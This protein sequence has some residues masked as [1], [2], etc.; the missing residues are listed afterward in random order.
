MC[1]PHLVHRAKSHPIPDWIDFGVAV[2]GKDPASNQ[3]PLSLGVKP[4]LVE[5]V[6]GLGDGEKVNRVVRDSELLSLRNL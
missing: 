6:N 4:F 1:I 3:D 2:D 5:P